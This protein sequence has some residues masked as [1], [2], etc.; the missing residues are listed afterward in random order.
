M[1]E[2]VRK[3]AGWSIGRGRVGVGVCIKEH[4]ELEAGRLSR[5]GT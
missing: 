3:R 5:H 4:R 2:Q 1:L